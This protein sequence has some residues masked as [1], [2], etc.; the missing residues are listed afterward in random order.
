MG[1]RRGGVWEEFEGIKGQE[2]NHIVRVSLSKLVIKYNKNK[3]RILNFS[4]TDFQ[5]LSLFISDRKCTAPGV[6]SCFSDPGK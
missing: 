2:E 1:R 5:S 6:N 3:L 4:F